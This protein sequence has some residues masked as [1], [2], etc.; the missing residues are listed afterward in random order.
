M[1]DFF[2]VKITIDD[3]SG[4]PPPKIVSNIDNGNL[5]LTAVISSDIVKKWDK[6]SFAG[7]QANELAEFFC[8]VKTVAEDT[9][10][11]SI[12]SIIVD[13]VTIA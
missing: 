11:G 3:G 2:V 6:A 10:T 1:A 7:T 12:L 5:Q 9:I 13:E 4:S 8:D